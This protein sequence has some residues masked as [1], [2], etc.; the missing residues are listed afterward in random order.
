MRLALRHL[1]KSPGCTVAA[2]TTLALA[3]G[4]S[5]AIF[6]AVYTVLLKP[7]PIRDPG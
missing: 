3:I 4:A 6:S 2:V 1:R 7:M 5:T